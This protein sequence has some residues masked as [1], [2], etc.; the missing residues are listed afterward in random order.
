MYLG[1]EFKFEMVDARC[2]KKVDRQQGPG[3]RL[4][5]PEL[6]AAQQINPPVGV[7]LDA[8]QQNA[9]STLVA[10]GPVDGVRPI[11]GPAHLV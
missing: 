9:H 8:C 6:A 3:T 5:G 4:A 2:S 1:V 7:L 11:L 10:V